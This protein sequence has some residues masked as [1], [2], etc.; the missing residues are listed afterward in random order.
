MREIVHL[1]AGQCG[2]QIGAKVSSQT[3]LKSYCYLAAILILLFPFAVLGGYLRRA[4]HRPN[5]YLPWRLR[6]SVGKDQ[7]LLQRGY[8][9]QVRAQGRA[10]GLG[11]RYHGL[12]QVRTLRTNLQTRQLCFW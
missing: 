11:A 2:N 8:R 5:W 7:R 1:Q 4:R 12:G 10:S 6:P 9:R 3:L